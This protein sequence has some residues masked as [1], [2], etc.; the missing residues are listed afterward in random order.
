M[1]RDPEDPE[2]DE[3]AEPAGT[4]RITS[5]ATIWIAAV[6]GGLTGWIVT[7]MA[8]LLRGVPPELPWTLVLLLWVI[9]GAVAVLAWSTYRRVHTER[10][11]I[12]ASR[13][14]R[15]LVLGKTATI[16]G[17]YGVGFLVVFGALFLDRI[18]V[19]TSAWRVVL[20]VGGALGCLAMV[21]AGR[22]LQRA[23]HLPDE[24]DHDTP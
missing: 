5:W 17:G 9:A 2:P 3:P 24:P 10:R 19:A 12:A 23:C 22:A 15:L 13:G 1:S 4:I 7:R 8:T 21:F 11:W 14:I 18:Q 20:G 16:V 6:L